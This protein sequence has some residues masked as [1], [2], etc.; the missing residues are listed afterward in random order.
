MSRRAVPSFRSDVLKQMAFFFQWL[1]WRSSDPI[2]DATR[3][4]HTGPEEQDMMKAFGELRGRLKSTVGEKA[5]SDAGEGWFEAVVNL[6]DEVLPKFNGKR[7]RTGKGPAD[8]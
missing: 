2:A 3:G 5:L 1:Y 4:R 6:G 7:R 8:P